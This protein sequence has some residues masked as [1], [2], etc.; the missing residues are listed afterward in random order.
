MYSLVSVPPKEDRPSHD[1]GPWEGSVGALYKHG[2]SSGCVVGSVSYKVG[3]LTTNDDCIGP[4]EVVVTSVES[5][6]PLSFVVRCFQSHQW[7]ILQNAASG[8]IHPYMY[9]PSL[10]GCGDSRPIVLFQPPGKNI[11][12][13]KKPR[14]LELLIVT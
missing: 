10:S 7:S 4:Q 3:T 8:N 14:I 9:L 6:Y 11:A 5:I 13:L 2:R 12:L 1:P